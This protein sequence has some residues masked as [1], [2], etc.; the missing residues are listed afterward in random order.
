MGCLICFQF[1]NNTVSPLCHWRLCPLLE[2][3]ALY[4][5]ITRD[6]ACIISEAFESLLA[7]L[8]CILCGDT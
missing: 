4:F 8:P 5:G 6:S 1:S 7:Y 3:T 2:H